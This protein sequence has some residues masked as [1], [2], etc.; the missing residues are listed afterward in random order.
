MWEGS[1]SPWPA[2]LKHHGS[3]TV[4]FDVQDRHMKLRFEIT[5]ATRPLLSVAAAVDAGK[6]VVFSPSGS[7]ISDGLATEETD[8]P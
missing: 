7:Y 6:T 3:T 4:L 2:A 8:A 1:P 5:D